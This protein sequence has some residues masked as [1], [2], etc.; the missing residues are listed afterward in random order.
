MTPQAPMRGFSASEFESRCARAQRAMHKPS[1][2]A[3]LLLH[4]GGVSMSAS[5]QDRRRTQLP[6]IPEENA[7]VWQRI[8]AN[9]FTSALRIL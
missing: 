4:K 1:S 3:A 5:V 6:A 8:G 7:A 2:A 9:I